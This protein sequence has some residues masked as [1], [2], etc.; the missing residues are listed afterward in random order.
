MTLPYRTSDVSPRRQTG[1]PVPQAESWPKRLPAVL[2][3]LLGVMQAP[4]LAAS[5][6]WDANGV[7]PGTGGTGNWD[8][9]SSLP[10]CRIARITSG[11]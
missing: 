7:D 11:L 4:A 5:Y 1:T 2:A 6:S 10:Y 8:T 9:A 3:V